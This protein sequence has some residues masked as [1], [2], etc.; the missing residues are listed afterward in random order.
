MKV[1]RLVEFR[2]C[3][4][5]LVKLD[6]FEVVKCRR[7]MRALGGAVGAIMWCRLFSGA[8]RW[9]FPTG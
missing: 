6:L 4:D 2:V 8:L 1:R 7:F 5:G 3:G 9:V